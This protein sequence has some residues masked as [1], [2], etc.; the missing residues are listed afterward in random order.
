MG[1]TRNIDNGNTGLVNWRQ[2]LTYLT[3]GNSPLPTVNK[4]AE[5]KQSAGGRDGVTKSQFVSATFWFDTHETSEDR[6][7]SE[8]FDR[9]SMIK[10]ILF[11]IN[12]R[13]QQEGEPLLHFDTLVEI[14][15]IPYARNNQAKI[16]SDFLFSPVKA[17]AI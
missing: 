6:Q 8:P 16:F 5:A 2:F 3:L 12:A 7:Y 15:R 11:D 9:A 13:S 1:M 17:I 10:E 4:L 14:L